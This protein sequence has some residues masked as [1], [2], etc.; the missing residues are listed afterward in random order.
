MRRLGCSA[1]PR[2]SFTTS[3]TTSLP[4]ALPQVFLDP[5][6][7]GEVLSELALLFSKLGLGERAID[8]MQQAEKIAVGI[9]DVG[10]LAAHQACCTS[11]NVLA[12]LVQK[13]KY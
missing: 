6:A 5:H 8:C 1:A 3:F 11:A 13:H 7:L 10:A 9:D 12:L 4:L 2:S